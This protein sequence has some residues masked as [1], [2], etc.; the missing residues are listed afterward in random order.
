MLRGSSPDPSVVIF[1]VGGK[2]R[3]P[4]LIFATNEP[5]VGP[6]PMGPDPL[7]MLDGFYSFVQGQLLVRLVL[8]PFASPTEGPGVR[9][10]LVLLEALFSTKNDSDK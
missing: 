9:L 3:I 5:G 1:P 6:E 4:L 7:L 10:P 8:E 2:P